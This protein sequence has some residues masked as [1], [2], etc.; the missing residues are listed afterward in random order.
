MLSIT[1]TQIHY[2]SAN[3][4]TL[5]YTLLFDLVYALKL[6]VEKNNL[7]CKISFSVVIKYIYCNKI[8]KLL[9]K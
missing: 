7:P 4:H 1:R 5:S 2:T 3:S 8:G 9:T 6:N